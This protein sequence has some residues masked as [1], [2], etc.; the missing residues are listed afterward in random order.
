MA[1]RCWGCANGVAPV[2]HAASSLPLE[3]LGGCWGCHVFAC[4]AHARRDPGAGKWL[5]YACVAADLAVSAGLEDADIRGTR[6]ADSAE[7]EERFEELAAQT[8]AYRAH[9]RTG[10]GEGRLGTLLGD[11]GFRE[12]VDWGL[13]GDAVGVGQFLIEPVQAHVDFAKRSRRETI[14]TPRLE[15]ILERLTD[16]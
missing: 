16:G 13:A 8:A 2:G 3:P 11:T 5:C 6:F 15:A 10:E 9:W 14:L 12:T 4:E 7:F 1:A